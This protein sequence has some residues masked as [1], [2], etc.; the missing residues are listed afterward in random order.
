MLKDE[1]LSENDPKVIGFKARKSWAASYVYWHV[2][3]GPVPSGEV[4]G[5][6]RDLPPVN[7]LIERI[8]KEAEEILRKMPQKYLT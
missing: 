3:D 5:R 1:K 2:D 7:G 6:I 8:M 4:Q